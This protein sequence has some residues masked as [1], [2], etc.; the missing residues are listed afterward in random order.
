MITINAKF[1]E[2]EVKEIEELM[3][4]KALFGDTGAPST[5]EEFDKWCDK[6]VEIYHEDKIK[7]DIKR[8]KKIERESQ[9]GFKARR[10]WKRYDTEIK[11]AREQIEELEKNIKY[12]EKK[13][14]EYAKQYKA[15]T[16]EDVK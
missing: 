2:E 9:P 7:E 12:Y 13:K 10:N 15:E 8:Q 4:Y 6:V 14:A 3:Y 5:Q 1:T 11:K 16:G